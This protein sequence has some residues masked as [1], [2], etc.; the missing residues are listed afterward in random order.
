MVRGA[1]DVCE[2]GWKTF[3]IPAFAGG[4]PSNLPVW[5]Q[6]LDLVFQ[7]LQKV[8]PWFRGGRE[9]SVDF[10]VNIAW[11]GVCRCFFGE[12]GD[13]DMHGVQIEEF[14]FW[15]G[16]EVD[17]VVL[18]KGDSSIRGIG[19]DTSSNHQEVSFG[20]VGHWERERAIRLRFFRFGGWC[21]NTFL[22]GTRREDR[23]KRYGRWGSISGRIQLNVRH[24]VHWYSGICWMGVCQRCFVESYFKQGFSSRPKVAVK[25]FEKQRIGITTTT[26]DILDGV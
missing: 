20:Q 19:G 16:R 23:N 7:V 6:L 10:E 4:T 11:S 22:R 8:W 12:G 21:M 2:F 25:V 24:Q 18:N 13:G 9:A 14:K 26:G 3:V 15:L 17:N 1:I 5:L